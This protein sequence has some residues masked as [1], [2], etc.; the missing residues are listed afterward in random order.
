MT[1]PIDEAPAQ[2]TQSLDSAEVNWARSQ[3]HTRRNMQAVFRRYVGIGY[4][5]ER[6]PADGL[7]GLRVYVAHAESEAPVEVLPPPGPRKYW[8]RRG[9]AMWLLGLPHQNITTHVRL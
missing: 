9:A 6:P 3:H 7:K 5:G 4:S 1:D 8:S 2:P